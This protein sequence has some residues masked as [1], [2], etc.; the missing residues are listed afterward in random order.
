M[1]QLFKVIGNTTVLRRQYLW[2]TIGSTSGVLL[3]HRTNLILEPIVPA[4]YLNFLMS[5]TK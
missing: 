4:D 1:K 3:H 5:A 2:E